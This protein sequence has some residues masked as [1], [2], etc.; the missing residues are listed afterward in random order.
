MAGGP[1]RLDEALN[2]LSGLWGHQSVEFPC[3]VG[4]LDRL[5]RN[6]AFL[7]ALRD[8]G[9]EIMAADL[10]YADKL[11]VGLMAVVAEHERDLISQRTR[12]ALQAAK[13][14]GVKLGCPNPAKGS[15]IGNAAQKARADQFAANV[16]PVITEIQAAGIATQQGIADALNA[17]GIQTARGGAWHPSSVRN[18]MGRAG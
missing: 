5:S 12:D 8:A 10:P 16:R 7:L 13:A 17:R 3:R 14:R 18:V 2:A 15:E 11:T 1:D 6:A 9:V 4:R